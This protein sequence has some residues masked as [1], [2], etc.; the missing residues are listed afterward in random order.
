MRVWGMIDSGIEN[1]NRRVDFIEQRIEGCRQWGPA[2]GEAAAL[3]AL[4]HRKHGAGIGVRRQVD[5]IKLRGG[6]APRASPTSAEHAM[7]IAGL[8]RRIGLHIC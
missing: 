2:G 7:A 8:R 1:A 5:R 4:V 6:S 3:H